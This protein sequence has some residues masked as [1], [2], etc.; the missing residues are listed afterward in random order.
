MEK[1]Y[2]EERVEK[3]SLLF[4]FLSRTIEEKIERIRRELLVFP[5]YSLPL[6]LPFGTASGDQSD[7]N[8]IGDRLVQL[9]GG[10]ASGVDLGEDS[11]T[12]TAGHFS[13]P[14]TLSLSPLQL[15]AFSSRRVCHNSASALLDSFR[16]V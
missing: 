8:A 6:S 15:L 10:D 3:P 5:L 14:A 2:G 12:D 11:D 7:E 16:V 1:K 13:S 9:S 4:F